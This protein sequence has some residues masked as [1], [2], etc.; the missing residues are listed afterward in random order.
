M[1]SSLLVEVTSSTKLGDA[2]MVLDTLLIET[3]ELMGGLRVVQGRV[4]GEGGE[5]KVTYPAKTDLVGVKNLNIV[6]E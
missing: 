1:T 4:V 6:R 5:L 3:A 2:K